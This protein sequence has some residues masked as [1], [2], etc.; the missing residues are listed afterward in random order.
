MQEGYIEKYPSFPLARIN[1]KLQQATVDKEFIASVKN[2][3][4]LKSGK[5]TEELAE[6]LN[7][8]SESILCRKR[9]S[10]FF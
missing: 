3:K 4:R 9:A 6:N 5:K 7:I 8:C 10:A 1:E 2:T